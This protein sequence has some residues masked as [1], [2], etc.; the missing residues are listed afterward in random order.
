MIGDRGTR[1]S[2]IILQREESRIVVYIVVKCGVE[3]RFKK[4]YGH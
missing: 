1:R 4:N 3:E 2:S